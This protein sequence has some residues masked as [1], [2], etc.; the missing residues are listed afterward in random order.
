VTLPKWFLQQQ[1]I[2]ITFQTAPQLV[3]NV[4]PIECINMYPTKGN[5][6]INNEKISKSLTSF[7]FSMQIKIQ[8]LIHHFNYNV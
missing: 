6:K 8:L 2:E 1:K 7:E 4:K 3:F 5:I